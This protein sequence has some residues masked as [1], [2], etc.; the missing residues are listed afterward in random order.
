VQTHPRRDLADAERGGG[1][2]DR[3]LVDRDEFEDGSF[4]L[5]EPF[6]GGEGTAAV[7]ALGVE[8]VLEACDVVGLRQPSPRDAQVTPG[9]TAARRRSEETTLRATP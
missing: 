8:L 5:G 3:E 9:L 2:G 1:L 4:A 7:R 6:Q